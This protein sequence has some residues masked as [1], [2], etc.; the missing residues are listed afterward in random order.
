GSPKL[1]RRL[2]DTEISKISQIYMYNLNNYHNLLKER[3]KYLKLLNV[4]HQQKDEYLEVL[5]EQMAHIQVDL[6]KKRYEFIELLNDI[7][8]T[9][10]D[11]IALHH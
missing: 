11:Y 1:R 4:K 5:S 10:Y 3:N 2:I 8:K 6:I 9:M 7:S